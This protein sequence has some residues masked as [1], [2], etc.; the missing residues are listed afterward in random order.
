VLLFAT[1]AA[2]GGMPAASMKLGD[3]TVVDRLVAQL[4][5]LDDA[6][7]TIVT[8][9]GWAEDLRAAGHSAVESDD[10]AG[11][12]ALIGAAAGATDGAIVLAD[13]D[14]V[15]HRGALAEFV[16]AGPMRSDSRKAPDRGPMR[17]DSRKAP[18]GGVPQSHAA[19][20]GGRPTD[21]ATGQ[22]VRCERGMIISV[23]THQREVTRPDA[24]FQGLVAVS[25]GDSRP[26]REAC[27]ALR[28]EAI[29]SGR[30]LDADAGGYGAVG[31]ALLG[32][33]RTGVVVS[34]LDPRPL[35]R[36]RTTSLLSL[37]AS[38]RLS[39]TQVTLISA[40]IG[41]LAAIL[42]AIG[43][44]WLFVVGAVLLYAAFVIGCQ[45]RPLAR[46][47][48]RFGR[49]DGW[50]DVMTGRAT[51]YVLLGGAA[52]GGVGMH[53]PGV[54]GFA[55]AT[56]VVLAVRHA[57]D[58]WYGDFRDRQARALAVVPIGSKVDAIAG[59]ATRTD[60]SERPRARFVSW[61]NATAALPRG[62]FFLLMALAAAFGGPR[63]MLITALVALAGSLALVVGERVWQGLSSPAAQVSADGT[64]NAYERDDGPIARLIGRLSAGARVPPLVAVV[65]G[66]LG[67]LA[68]IAF[69]IDGEVAARWVV[70]PVAVL[71]LF[72]ATSSPLGSGTAADSAATVGERRFDWLAAAGVRT[73]EYTFIVVAGLVG[74]AP[75][76]LTYTLLLALALYHDDASA[77]IAGLGSPVRG[78]PVLRGWDLRVAIIA[79]TTAIGWATATFAVAAIAIGLVLGVG[80][81]RGWR[82]ATWAATARSAAP[83]DAV[84]SK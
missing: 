59:T 33:V 35:G 11:D 23:G 75:M 56:I 5:D 46:V 27:A 58:A 26:L 37:M 47:T 55:L 28:T 13:A 19:V 36:P 16:E 60:T 51:E 3:T 9:P 15:A 81:W 72:A 43:A 83:A 52:I 40:G 66:L 44:R 45:S 64:A 79:V 39:P 78:E 77:R 10:V 2:P 24:S 54:W 18:D 12:L 42:F 7:I 80:A 82:R 57:V 84:L 50:L 48:G 61:L 62:D 68:T 49:F 73:A 14:L 38:R 67:T 74:G 32:L 21:G 69:A 8:R 41:L 29:E 1:Q 4:N 63:V 30:D 22:P 70:I 20:T 71:T 34:A 6:D 53:E 76:W 31:L 17:S 65:P 25:E